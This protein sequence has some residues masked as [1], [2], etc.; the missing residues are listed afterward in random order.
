MGGNDRLIGLMPFAAR[1]GI[2]L[3]SAEPRRVVGRLA[4]DEALCTTGGVLHGG[5]LM[6][7]ADSLGGL[8]AF[9]N[10]PEGANTATISSSTNFLRAVRS[11]HVT[12]VCHPVHVGRSVI[13]V[14]T[15]LRDGEDKLAAQ[16]TQAQA[17]LAA[18]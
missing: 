13:V 16:V 8:C 10:L 17:V 4:W 1:L 15:E 2:V 9:L 14:Q 3:E 12:G 6:T 7:L 5:V 18:R 11:G